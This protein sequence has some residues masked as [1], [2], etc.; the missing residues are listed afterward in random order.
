MPKR[1]ANKPSMGPVVR[2]PV[3]ADLVGGFLNTFLI[4]DFDNAKATPAFHRDIWELFCSPEPLVAVAAPRGHAKSTAGTLAYG[5]SALL[6]GSDDFMLLVSATEALAAS[7]LANM[8]RVLS[9]NADLRTEFDV[10]VLKSNETELVVRTGNREF[11]VKGKGAEQSVRGIIWRNK[12]PSLILIDDL[13]EDEAVMSKERRQ[14]LKDWFDNALMPCGSDSRR[15]RFLGTILHIDSLLANSIADDLWVGVKF[16]AHKS[17]DNFSEILWPEKWPESRLRFER[18]RYLNNGNPSGYSQEY[19]SKPIAEADAFF[20]RSDFKPMV[21]GDHSREK[22]MYAAIEFALFASDKGDNTVVV[23]GGMDSDGMLHIV[24]CVAGR[25]DPLD[26]TN[27]M[28]EMDE[29]YDITMWCVED[30]NIGKAIGP[31]LNQEMVKRN[32]FMNL[33][34][35]RPHKDKQARATSI[36]ARMRAGGVRMD[37]GAPWYEDLHAELIEFPRG[38]HDDRVDALAWLGLMLDGF[39]PALTRKEL[40]ELAW[41]EEEEESGYDDSGRSEV[42]GY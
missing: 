17:F 18:Q 14:K 37:F 9:D 19:L 11:C 3:D 34:R 38:H 31:F 28:F 2:I 32:R 5:L 15:V 6:F 4:D 36:R 27:L 25:M 26:S 23:V 40:D 35:I 24:D 16:S 13:E 12:R 1:P 39:S 22:T 33:H 10:E 42:T 41:R 8:A 30:D 7:H 20:R 21:D 29:K